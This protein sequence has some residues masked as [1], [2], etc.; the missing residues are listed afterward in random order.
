MRAAVP[1]P[2][3]PVSRPRLPSPARVALEQI[4]ARREHDE[5]EAEP[6]RSEP[7]PMLSSVATAAELAW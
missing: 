5:V 4:R 2:L 3:P 7:L 1:P 6:T